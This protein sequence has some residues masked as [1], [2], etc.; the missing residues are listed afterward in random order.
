MSEDLC[1][2]RMVLGTQQAPEVTAEGLFLVGSELQATGTF[3]F[4]IKAS[5]H[6]DA[7]HM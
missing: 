6:I 1:L 2:P 7:W 3:F 5:Q 4:T